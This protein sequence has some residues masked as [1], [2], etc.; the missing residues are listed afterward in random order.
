M[1]RT[2]ILFAHRRAPQ[3]LSHLTKS[4]QAEQFVFNW[5]HIIRRLPHPLN[6]D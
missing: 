5:M 1:M 2:Q 3:G 6:R 4:H